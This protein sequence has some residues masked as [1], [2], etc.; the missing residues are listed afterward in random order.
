MLVGL[1]VVAGAWW[2]VFRFLVV[3][4]IGFC[5]DDVYNVLCGLGVCFLVCA[6]GFDCGLVAVGCL[7][8][9]VCG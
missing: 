7:V 9:V 4:L 2:V 1:L 5:L 6:V 8:F 3:F